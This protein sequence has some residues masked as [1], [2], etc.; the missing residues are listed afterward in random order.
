LTPDYFW[1][2]GERPAAM[3]N[4]G[5]NP[6]CRFHKPIVGGHPALMAD[7]GND[8]SERFLSKISAGRQVVL[9][10]LGHIGKDGFPDNLLQAMKLAPAAWFW[11]VRLHPHD[12]SDPTVGN[13]LR[14]KLD[15]AGV[16][17]FEIEISSSE[18][19]PKLLRHVQRHVTPYSS[20]AVEATAFGVPTVFIHPLGRK[21]FEHI[22]SVRGMVYAEDPEDIVKE[23]EAPVGEVET[24]VEADR[25]KAVAILRNLTARRRPDNSSLKGRL[26][27]FAYRAR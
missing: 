18:P 24:L 26:A 7:Y 14:T 22:L 10:T 23:L 27:K 16:K 5:A 3:I 9:A 2:W 12:C 1:V 19:L 6:K 17:N 25:T 21:N 13:S 15:A 20:S 11:L 8:F 4:R